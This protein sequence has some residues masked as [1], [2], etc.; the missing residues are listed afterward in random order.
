[1]QQMQQQQN[2]FNLQ[3]QNALQLQQQQLN[4]QAP[5]TQT[6]A[7]PQVAQQTHGLMYPG[8]T[9]RFAPY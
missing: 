9:Q 8:Y 2:A 7:L 3:Q 5:L 4:L 1:M 6:T